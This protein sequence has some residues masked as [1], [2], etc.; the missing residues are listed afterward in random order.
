MPDPIGIVVVDDHP[1]FRNGLVQVVQ[2]DPHF[3]VLAEGES[4][5]EAID[6]AHL[7]QPDLLLLD[8]TMKDSGIDAI[9]SILQVSPMTRIAILTASEQTADITRALRAGA[10]GYLLKGTTANELLSILHELVDGGTHISSRAMSRLVDDQ[11]RSTTQSAHAA[12]LETLSPQEVRVLRLVAQG[13]NNREI[14][15]ELGI[16]EKT[17]KFHLSNVY[18]KLNVRN[19]VEASLAAR[20]GWNLD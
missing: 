15:N 7:H 1:I 17:I 18:A 13:R 9:D 19:R 2:L 5:S 20:R 6:L 16:Q 12:P 8:V 4:A 10:T 14:G 11:R 3:R